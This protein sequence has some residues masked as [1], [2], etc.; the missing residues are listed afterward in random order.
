MRELELPALVEENRR[1]RGAVATLECEL[2]AVRETAAAA[3]G[4][5]QGQLVVLRAELER[6]TGEV[7]VAKQELSKTVQVR[8]ATHSK[9]DEARRRLNLTAGEAEVFVKEF[10]ETSRANSALRSE[11]SGLRSERATLQQQCESRSQHC[12]TLI[13]ENKRLVDQ[14][15]T[16]RRE[17]V[18][19]DQEGWKLRA[20]I[21]KAATRKAHLE[22]VRE[23]AASLFQERPQWQAPAECPRSSREPA[24]ASTSFGA[25][26]SGGTPPSRPAA[27]SSSGGGGGAAA[28]A[29]AARQPRPSVSGA[30]AAPAAAAASSKAPVAAKAQPRGLADVTNRASAGV[31]AG[32]WRAGGAAKG[33]A[34]VERGAAAVERG[35]RGSAGARTGG[36]AAAGAGGEH[37]VEDTWCDV[38][39]LRQALELRAQLQGKE[40]SSAQLQLLGGDGGARDAGGKSGVGAR[41]GGGAAAAD[42]CAAPAVV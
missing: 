29:A 24:P 39:L 37:A 36:H 41:G 34:A 33:A 42:A 17:L 16:L 15:A 31:G 38:S 5:A 20:Q 30:T 1:A 6:L 27:R 26:S 9:L 19:L 32:A 11:V 21:A 22:H 4:A 7:L 8:Q 3:E 14:V 23:R 10:D 35:A 13:A 25:A 40:L 28:G 18:A 12:M 2:S